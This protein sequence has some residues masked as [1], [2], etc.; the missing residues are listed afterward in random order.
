MPT[1]TP[2][3][4]DR[5]TGRVDDYVRARPGYPPAIVDDLAAAGILAPGAVV[6]DIGSGTG[7]SSALFLAAGHEVVGVEPNA[8]M[9]AAAEASLA[10]Y[11]L[12]RS[13]PGSAEAT[14]LPD[15]SVDLVVA[16]Q[17]F[18]WFDAART[19]TEF[20]RILTDPGWVALIWNARRSS[21][22]PF[23]AAYEALLLAF[24]TDYAQV[25]HRGVGAERLAPFFGGSWETRRY[26]NAQELDFEGLRSR[27]LSSSYI[28]AP[29]RPEHVAMLE[30]LRSIFDRHS[31]DGRV[32]ILY[33][34]E[35]HA[36]RLPPE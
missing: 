10:R 11:P 24:G 2:D 29:D 27:L 36:G 8:P 13:L 1:P 5:F 14:G 23:L 18:H 21:G 22:T 19:R 30:R 12:F 34:T 15:G 31:M 16:A 28:P 3:A 35:V 9:R 25:G 33:D 26:E 6:A 7:I 4:R 20:R 32:R 17:A